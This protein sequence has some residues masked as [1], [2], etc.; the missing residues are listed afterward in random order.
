MRQEYRF[1]RSAIVLMLLVLV[2]VVL[3]I[4]HA[5]KISAGDS[6]SIEGWPIVRLFAVAYGSMFVT[7]AVGYGILR[8]LRHNQRDS[9][10]R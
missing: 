5:R 6:S 3:A 1:P 2:G 10:Q 8:M 7:G 4:E 9:H